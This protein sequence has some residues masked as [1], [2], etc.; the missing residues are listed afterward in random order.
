[1]LE[2]GADIQLRKPGKYGSAFQLAV[3]KRDLKIIKLL[4]DHGRNVNPKDW[5][6]KEALES[7]KTPGNERIREFLLQWKVRAELSSNPS[8]GTSGGS[9]GSIGL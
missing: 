8:V 9:E 1:L 6:Y 3:N 7:A 2:S 4:L 5:W